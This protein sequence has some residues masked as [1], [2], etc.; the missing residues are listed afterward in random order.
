[1]QK[2]SDNV[3]DRHLDITECDTRLKTVHKKS[4]HN[5]KDKKCGN[6][7]VNN[8]GVNMKDDSVNSKMVMKHMIKKM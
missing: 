8:D 7:N 5:K 2:K 3:V 6:E 1:M 4:G